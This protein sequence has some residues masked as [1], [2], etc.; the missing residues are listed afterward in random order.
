ADDRIRKRMLEDFAKHGLV[1]VATDYAL[2]LLA[3]SKRGLSQMKIV[4]AGE[5]TVGPDAALVLAWQQTS[6]DA[7]ELEFHGRQVTRRALQGHL[8]VRRSD[9]LP[10]RIK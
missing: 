5:D 1:D 10:L 4:P 9:G 7:G 2:I 6:A 3:F 8:W